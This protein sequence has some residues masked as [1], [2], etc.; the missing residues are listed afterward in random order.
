MAEQK[1]TYPNESYSGCDMVATILLPNINKPGKTAYAI[2]E[3]QTVSYSIHMERHPVRS[4]SNIN[5]KDYVMG[6]RTIAGSLVF[7][8]FNKH[9]ANKIM[10]EVSN[11]V[12]TGYAFLLDEIPP[13]DIVISLA[14]EYGLRSRLAILGVRLVNEG[15]VMSINDVYT[16]NT[17]QFV[18]T[19]LEYL[20]DENTYTSGNKKGHGQYKI[21]EETS[22]VRN[23]DIQFSRSTSPFIMN[24]DIELNYLVTQAATEL[25]QGIVELWLNPSKKT[26]AI[27]ISGEKANKVIDMETGLNFNNRA[28][29]HLPAGEYTAVW[30]DSIDESN[31]VN[32][33][34]VENRTTERSI[35]PAPIIEYVGSDT[36]SIY[37]NVRQ[38]TKVIYETYNKETLRT[39]LSG[40]RAKLM[41]LESNKYYRIA[42]CDDNENSIS[43]YSIIKTLPHDYDHYEKFKEYLG[44]NKKALKNNNFEIYSSI[45]DEGKNL[46]TSKDKYLSITD[47]FIDLNKTYKDKLN[48]I[49]KDDFEDDV[50]YQEEL[51][52]LINLIDA[53]IEVIYVSFN[54]NN[55][56]IYGYNYKTMVIDPP[57][58]ED[59]S[60]CTNNFLAEYK[61][62]EMD[63]EKILTATR[64]VTDTISKKEFRDIGNKYMCTFNGRPGGRYSAYSVDK[65]GFKSP[66]TDFYS[67]EDNNRISL[68]EEKDVNDEKIKYELSRAYSLYSHK[69]DQTL[70]EEEIKRVLVE[71]IKDNSLKNVATPTLK[72]VTSE[73]IVITLNELEKL[74]TDNKLMVAI[75]DIDSSLIN[76]PKYKVPAK[77]EVIFNINEHGIRPNKTYVIWVEDKEEQQ[78]SQTIT[79]NVKEFDEIIESR[80]YDIN[81]YFISDI[82]KNLRAEFENEKLLDSVL[83]SILYRHENELEN[84]KVNI[85]DNILEDIIESFSKLSNISKILYSFFK[86]YIETIYT[87][88]NLFFT[89]EPVLN[90]E[91]NKILINEEC[92]MCT[93]D[94]NTEGFEKNIRKI[95][96]GEEIDFNDKSCPYTISFF[97][98]NEI[99]KRS[100]LILSSNL[101]NEYTTYKMKVQVNK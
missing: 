35:L 83:E 53:C 91:T 46:N 52:R 75:C 5:V 36:I 6:P 68:M 40:R 93:I 14:N 34:V 74:L 55:D 33:R 59:I 63:F 28:V 70:N 15:Q 51:D 84:T 97:I 95:A 54:I 85:L 41:D 13:F 17:Y 101:N 49:N 22:K 19:D 87:V 98:N 47:S 18:A 43:D 20:T 29:V 66:K 3:L 50:Q 21:V 58:L 89:E 25:K 11:S 64:R 7:A 73:K 72:E 82:V 44:Y 78:V 100:G 94:I 24:K 88:N 76:R 71:I 31:T 2:G 16:E 99:S 80:E 60:A 96:A 45:V 42:T 27:T 61:T 4:I 37:S 81:K 65:Y 86:V 90:R 30:A 56:V 23:N 8:V 92:Y 26:G 77:N 69:F 32:F 57:Q 39:K 79:V 48:N 67:L 38:H 1:Y 9:F 10:K 12:D 62:E